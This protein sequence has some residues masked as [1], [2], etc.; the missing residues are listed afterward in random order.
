VTD[1]GFSGTEWDRWMAN[2]RTDVTA[3]EIANLRLSHYPQ[4]G[5]ATE[6]G[7]T[8]FFCPQCME[9]GTSDTNW[10][11]PCAII[12]LVELWERGRDG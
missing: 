9:H 1:V 5:W 2:P 4:E 12:R 11:W 6:E 8:F 10:Y 3:A 7:G